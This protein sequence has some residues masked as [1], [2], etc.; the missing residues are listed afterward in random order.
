MTLHL[1]VA[2]TVPV[3]GNVD[4]NLEHHLRLVRLA[5]RSDAQVLVF[6]ELSL[7]GYEIGRA[8]EL[9]FDLAD[10]RLVPLMDAAA[11]HAMTLIVGAPVRDGARLH[12]AAFIFTPERGIGLYTKQRMG[13]FDESARLDGEAPPA[14]ATVFAPGARDPLIALHGRSAALAVCADVGHAG[15]AERAA[16]RGARAYLAGMFV[17]P[18]ECEREAARLKGYAVQHAMVVAA[19]NY[20]GPSGG[21]AAAGRSTIW[22]ETGEVIARLGPTGAGVAIAIEESGTWRGTTLVHPE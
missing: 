5:S 14:E 11:E 6:P 22:S 10:T 20:G 2:Q 1:A 12:I 21:L 18:S 16:R 8:S 15:H 3:A 7:T 13:A 19:A 4:A 17:I 9:A